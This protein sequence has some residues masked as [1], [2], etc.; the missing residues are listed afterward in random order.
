MRG[1]D[2][3]TGSLFSYVGIEG[4]L[5]PNHPK[6]R[7]PRSFGYVDDLAGGFRKLMDSPD[8]I[9]GSMSQLVR[10]PLPADDP[11]QR[12]PDITAA[13]TCWAGSPHPPQGRAHRTIDQFDKL[14]AEG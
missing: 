14:L 7:R 9:T 13:A 12:R 4:R 6:A 3:R 2:E 5:R 1:S 10:E 8:A 11:K